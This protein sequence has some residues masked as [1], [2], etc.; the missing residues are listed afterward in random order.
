MTEAIHPCHFCLPC[1]IQHIFNK[2][3]VTLGWIVDEDMGH[4]ADE[5]AV[6]NDGAA[7]QERCQ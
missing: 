7:G 4:G 3:P 2:D 5:F 1:R 6:L